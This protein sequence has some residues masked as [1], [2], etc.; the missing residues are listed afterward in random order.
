MQRLFTTPLT[1]LS[2]GTDTDQSQQREQLQ[3]SLT[4]MPSSLLDQVRVAEHVADEH[5]QLPRL[6]TPQRQ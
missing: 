1:Q 2:Q 3:A 5:Q 4:G 6:Q